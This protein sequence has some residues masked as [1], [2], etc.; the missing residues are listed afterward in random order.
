MHSSNLLPSLHLLY[1]KLQMSSFTK[2][3]CLD[4]FTLI[5]LDTTAERVSI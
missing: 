2:P 5:L 3:Q 1:E 4:F